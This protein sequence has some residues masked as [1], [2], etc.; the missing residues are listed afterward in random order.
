MPTI[1]SQI[2]DKATFDEM[3]KRT[4][5]FAVNDI[6][7]FIS[8]AMDES[9]M[10]QCAEECGEVL[11]ND[12]KELIL[13]TAHDVFGASHSGMSFAETGVYVNGDAIK[14]ARNPAKLIEMHAD[15]YEKFL[16]R[17]AP[18]RVMLRTYATLLDQNYQEWKEWKKAGSKDADPRD[19]LYGVLERHI[20]K[21]RDI[22]E[23]W[24]IDTEAVH[25]NVIRLIEREKNEMQANEA[26]QSAKD[27][28]AEA[29]DDRGNVI[30]I[31]EYGK[32]GPKRQ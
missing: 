15:V 7:D 13:D 29:D 28:K 12:E 6:S 26:P 24:N 22:F 27:E 30:D 16:E 11:D 25:E 31:N 8:D 2:V 9:V 4:E 18:V 23:R 17:I 1:F 5:H 3:L 20:E 19:R 14:A 21:H 32:N 10:A